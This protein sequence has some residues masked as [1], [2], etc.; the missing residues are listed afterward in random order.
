MSRPQDPRRP[1]FSFGNPFKMILPKGSYLSPKILASLNTFE[2]A[3]AERF[4]NLKPKDKEGVLSLSWMKFAI[5]LLCQ[6]H[7][8]IKTIITKLELH[9]SD[10]D[11]KWIDVYFDNSVKL[12]DICNAFSSELSRLSQGNLLL[13][14][15]LHN[16][17]SSSSKQFVKASSSLDG[18]RQRISS[19]NPRLENCFA[20]LS[21]LTET[22]NLPK[23]KNSAK[24]KVLIQAMYGVR[25]LT[26]LICSILA[27]AFS[28][29]A[30]KLVDLKVL[31]TCL[32]AEAF[33]NV[34]E[35]INGE[36]RNIFSSGK[37]PLLKELEGVDS[38]IKKLYPV[39]KDGLGPVEAE[40]LK[41][42]VSDFGKAAAKL[43]QGLDLLTK[44][45]DGFFQIVLTGRNA[46]LCNL[47]AGINVPDQ[48]HKT[49]KVEGQAVR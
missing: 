21:S 1:I 14:F 37:V 26:V 12:L 42:S 17:D 4:R 18:W 29:S 30:N 36:I 25:V 28:G 9:V 43:S 23:V 31:E 33:A 32:W 22:L 47:R 2:L 49:N 6:T 13:Q 44:Q 39:V 45:V 35:S 40:A 8:D 20:I 10:W 24:G 48:V 19:K 38:S 46:L 11:D 27:A 34:Q 5:E 15:A 3:L 41:N 16:L 7:I